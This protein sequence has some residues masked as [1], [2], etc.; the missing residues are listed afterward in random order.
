MAGPVVDSL[1]DAPL[2]YATIQLLRVEDEQ[3]EAGGITDEQ[4]QFEIEVAIGSYDAPLGFIGY[5]QTK[6]GS[7]HDFYERTQI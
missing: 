3:I 7:I 5:T 6:D 4:G 1:S 2:S